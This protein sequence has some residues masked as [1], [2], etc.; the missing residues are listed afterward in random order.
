MSTHREHA[1][2]KTSRQ[3]Q[4]KAQGDGFDPQKSKLNTAITRIDSVKGRR[5]GET[6]TKKSF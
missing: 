3:A 2:P 4:T 1:I 6:L 5:T